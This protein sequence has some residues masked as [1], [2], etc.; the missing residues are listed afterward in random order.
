MHFPW[1]LYINCSTTSF[2][3]RDRSPYLFFS[4]Y[5]FSPL[6]FCPA[7]VISSTFLSTYY[8]SFWIIGEGYSQSLIKSS[9]VLAWWRIDSSSDSFSGV[10]QCSLGS[11][12]VLPQDGQS[13]SP[14]EALLVPIAVMALFSTVCLIV[15]IPT[16]ILLGFSGNLFSSVFVVQLQFC[17]F[18]SKRW[19]LP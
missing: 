11:T 10:L 6:S 15:V 16:T 12:I 9:H 19:E 5:R 14:V 7:S 13:I 2:E 1:T 4:A 3:R 8:N 18:E 17:T